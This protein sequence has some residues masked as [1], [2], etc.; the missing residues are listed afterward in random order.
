MYV[1]SVTLYMLSR[2]FFGF[3]PVKSKEKAGSVPAELVPSGGADNG[4]SNDDEDQT[5]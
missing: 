4:N 2:R 3:D 5:L 1:A